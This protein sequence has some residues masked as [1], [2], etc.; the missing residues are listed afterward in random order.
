[1]D[2][3]LI[4]IEDGP[5]Y[6]CTSKNRSVITLLPSNVCTKVVYTVQHKSGKECDLYIKAVPQYKLGYSASPVHAM[7]E[8]Y[9]VKLLPCPAGFILLKSDGLCQCDPV[10][11]MHIASVTTC[12][13]NNQ[14]ILRPPNRWITATTVNDSHTYSVSLSCP[15]DYCS[16]NSL[17]LNLLNPDLQCQF[18]RT[19]VLCGQCQQ[20]LSA[21]FGSQAFT[22]FLLHQLPL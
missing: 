9:N 13:I 18:K 3:L 21:V 22:C 2:K 5:E 12:N 8:F 6:A 15:F 16:P 7:T 14:T 19:G 4:R 1:M 20:G 10:L 17:H 11:L